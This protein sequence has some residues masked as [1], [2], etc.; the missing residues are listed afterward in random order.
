MTEV[1][2]IYYSSKMK[3]YYFCETS[4]FGDFYA[5]KVYDGIKLK[6]GEIK[7]D[8]NGKKYILG[9]VE[10]VQGKNGFYYKC[11]GFVPAKEEVNE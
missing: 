10:K 9:Y 3:K 11:T 6:G 4:V 7:T 8:K 2:A 5:Q 1:K